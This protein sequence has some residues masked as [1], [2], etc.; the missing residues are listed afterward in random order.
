VALFAAHESATSE[1][2]RSWIERALTLLERWSQGD[3]S[4]RNQMRSDA[5]LLIL[6]ADPRF[7]KLAADVTIVPEEP[8]WVANREVTRLE[9]EAFINDSSYAGEKPQDRKESELYNYKEHRPTLDHPAQNVSWYDAVMY[10]NWLSRREGRTPAYRS[11]GKEKVNDYRNQE[12][13][14]VEVDM[15]EQV[16]SA[17]GYRLPKEVEWEVA[18]RAGSGTAWSTGSDESLLISYCQ[19]Y[20]S[21]LA[22][23]CGQKLPNARG[24]HDM[25]GNVWEW[26]WGPLGSGRVVRGG[27][28][29]DYAAYCRSASRDWFGPSN[30]NGLG[31]RVALSSPSGIP[32]SPEADK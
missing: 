22:S 30:R 23:V 15:W 31:F 11:V 13:Q 12:V 8:Y 28:W 27:G 5:D 2:K 24:L 17:N 26:C 9:F 4:S 18:C 21:K 20:P 10:C 29:S 14:E 16:E 7:V 3:E 1:E 25:H 6:H 19:M 32:K